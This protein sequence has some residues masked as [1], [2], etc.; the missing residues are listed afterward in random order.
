[1]KIPIYKKIIHTLG[2]IFKTVFWIAFSIGIVSAALVAFYFFSVASTA[3]SVNVDKIQSPVSSGIYDLNGNKLS[4]IGIERKYE[5]VKFEELPE[6]LINAVT[7]I[8]DRKFFTHNGYDVARVIGSTIKNAVQNGDATQG[9]GGS[10]ITQQVVKNTQNLRNGKLKI[11]IEDKIKEVIVANELEQKMSKQDIIAAYLNTN[12]YYGGRIVGVRAAAK[13]YFNKDVSQL[14]LPE[15]ALLAG[16]PQAPSYYNPY[17]PFQ[18]DAVS[19]EQADKNMKV[20]FERYRMVIM[21]M[22]D[23]GYISKIEADEAIKLPLAQLLKNGMPA[24]DQT[25]GAYTTAALN[26]ARQKLNLSDDETIPSGTKIYINVNNEIQ[27][28]GNEIQDTNNYIKYPSDNYDMSYTVIENKTGR[29]L[30]TGAGR[31]NNTSLTNFNNATHGLRQPGSTIKPLLDYAPA[32]EKFKWSSGK[33]VNDSPANFINTSTKIVNYD[34]KYK[35]VMSMTSAIADSRNVPAVLTYR[36]VN[37]DTSHTGNYSADFIKKLGI[38]LNPSEM[39]EAYAIGGFSTGVTTLQIASAYSAFA[40]GGKY[41]TPNFVSKIIDSDNKTL[42]EWTETADTKQAMSSETASIMTSALNYTIVSGGGNANNIAGLELAGKT[43][44]TDDGKGN[45]KDHWF[46]GYSPDY[47]IAVWGGNK[48]QNQP[49]YYSYTSYIS[50]VFKTLMKAIAKP[51][52][53]FVYSENTYQKGSNRYWKN[54]NNDGGV[55]FTSGNPGDNENITADT[56]AEIQPTNGIDTENPAVG[57]TP[58]TGNQQ[59][60]TNGQNGTQSGNSNNQQSGSFQPRTNN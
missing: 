33:M 19:A 2:V 26:E 28:L 45:A 48:N 36:E 3:P 31:N 40:N 55:L 8:E 16:I 47:T 39:V 20:P 10:T 14:T 52:S 22:V 54:Y 56:P 23:A 38:S 49:V 5:D 58:Q 46:V 53:K 50:T 21:S 29:I 25:I 18:S 30:A 34:N 13:Y 12:Y 17:A 15:S 1:M 7:A 43:G 57:T 4:D 9:A 27:K 44:T 51:G 60:N 24:S 32:I 37:R 42:Y 35:G 11:G 41:A 6:N 59:S